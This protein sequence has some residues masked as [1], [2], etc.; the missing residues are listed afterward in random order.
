MSQGPLGIKEFW[1][2]LAE[3]QRDSCLLYC[4]TAPGI[5]LWPAT[6]KRVLF[7]APEKVSAQLQ[8]CS[9]LRG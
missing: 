2:G 7:A 9:V 3:A 1:T 5:R 4:R 6:T 8:C